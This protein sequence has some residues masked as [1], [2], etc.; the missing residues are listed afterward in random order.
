MEKA[1]SPAKSA[2]NFGVLF[3]VILVIEFVLAYALN[4]DPQTNK[5]FGI[6]INVL[7]YLIIPV[8][9][10]YMG[11]NNYKNKLNEGFISLG[12]CLKIGV[13]ICLIAALIYGIFYVV[14]DMLFPEFSQELIAK[15]EKVMIE[16]NPDLPSDQREMAL[17]MTKKFMHPALLLPVTLVMYSFIGLIYSL[18]IGAIVKK[19][20]N[21]SF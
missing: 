6:T 15:V 9:L 5:G 17:S 18:I 12:Q 14:F 3:G 19:D 7:N 8:T 11:C 4:I 2:L 10:I 13:T 21:D 16:E 20:K 1:I